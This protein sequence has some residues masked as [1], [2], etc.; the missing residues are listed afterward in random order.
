MINQNFDDCD[1]EEDTR[2]SPTM[3]TRWMNSMT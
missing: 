2:V 3:A 1:K